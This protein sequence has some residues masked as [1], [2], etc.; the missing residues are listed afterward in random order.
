VLRD[1]NRNHLAVPD[2]SGTIPAH[3]AVT[4]SL[5]K[6]S[7]QLSNKGGEITLLTPDGKVAHR[8][9]YSKAQARREGEMIYF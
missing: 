6:G 8:V 4:V 5:P 7:M 1:V 2:A 3:G 9:S